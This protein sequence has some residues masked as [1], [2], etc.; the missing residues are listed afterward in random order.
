M[1]NKVLIY[2]LLFASLSYAQ[3]KEGQALIDSLLEELPRMKEDTLKVSL[4]N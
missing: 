4:L 1:K 2:I 3:N